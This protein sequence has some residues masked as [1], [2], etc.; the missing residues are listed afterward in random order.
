MR[1]KTKMYNSI[2]VIKASHFIKIKKVV[3]LASNYTILSNTKLISY[4]KYIFL[5]PPHS[6]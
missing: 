2:V 4:L 1:K 6:I 3:D 5:F